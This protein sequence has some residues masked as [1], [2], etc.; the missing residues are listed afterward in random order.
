MLGRTFLTSC[1]VLRECA[2]D[3]I[4]GIIFLRE[5]G[6]IIDIQEHTVTFST[7][8]ATDKSD[9]S[10]SSTFRVSAD[11]ITLARRS[12]LLA[13]VVCDKVRD[14]E[15]V[16]VENS[17]LLFALG[18]RRLTASPHFVTDVL[19]CLLPISVMSSATFFVAPSSR[20]PTL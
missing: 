10:H 20:L 7:E 17:P 13:D 4:L 12:S 11:R 16:A 8:R 2:R 14:D 5:H 19:R 1:L 18:V 15:G 6:A 9:D 3:F